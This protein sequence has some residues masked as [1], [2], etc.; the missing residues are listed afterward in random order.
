MEERVGAITGDSRWYSD[1]SR[2]PT[3]AL[4]RKKPPAQPADTDQPNPPDEDYYAP[5][6]PDA[7][8]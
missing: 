8:A 4:K 3:A 2:A 7:D 5:S 1:Q 6:E